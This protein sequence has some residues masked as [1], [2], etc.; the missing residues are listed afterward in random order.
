MRHVDAVD[1]CH[2]LA[3]QQPQ[4]QQ[5]STVQPNVLQAVCS[6]VAP[7]VNGSYR[8]DAGSQPPA[9]P[10]FYYASLPLRRS[11]YRHSFLNANYSRTLP[12][13]INHYGYSSKEQTYLMQDHNSK[14]SPLYRQEYISGG[15]RYVVPTFTGLLGLGEVLQQYSGSHR[16]EHGA[17]SILSSIGASYAVT[18]SDSDEEDF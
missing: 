7:S 14:V 15:D 2:N 18:T 11:H 10:Y 1:S 4:P 3:Q 6:A 12:R 5:T 8:E 9:D 16:R 17:A 13:S